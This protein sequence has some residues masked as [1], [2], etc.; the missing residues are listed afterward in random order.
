MKVPIESLL[1]REKIP[2]YSKFEESEANVLHNV[3]KKNY[4][5]IIFAIIVEM[6]Y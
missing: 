3:K 6:K 4:M 1:D 2:V 5:I